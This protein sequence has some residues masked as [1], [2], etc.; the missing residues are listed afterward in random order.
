M[1]VDIPLPA[2]ITH[3]RMKVPLFALL[4]AFLPLAGGCTAPG[5]AEAKV[6]FY[7]LVRAT[8]DTVDDDGRVFN[9]VTMAQTFYP[10]SV[11]R[12]QI[13]RIVVS[14]PAT[15]AGRKYLIALPDAPAAPADRNVARLKVPGEKLL[16]K[17]PRSMLDRGPR[18]IIDFADLGWP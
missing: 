11:S 16:L 5:S 6:G 4:V 9:V 7:V 8:V 13:T 17:L 10:G 18:Q 1:L 15:L 2:V 14:E 12:E 3:G